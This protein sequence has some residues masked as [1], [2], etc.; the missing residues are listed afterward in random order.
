MRNLRFLLLLLIAAITLC[1]ILSGQ[2]NTTTTPA[3]TFPPASTASPETAQAPIL[4]YSPP[5]AEYARAKAY[6]AAHYRHFFINSLYGLL[7]LLVLLRWRVAPRFRDLAERVSRRRFVQL[8]IFAPL[9]LLTVSIVTI[10]SDIWDQSLQRAFGLS[11]QKW[12]AWLSDW[13]TGQIIMLIVGT[14][15]VGILYAVIRRSPRRWWFYFWLASIPILLALFFLQPLVI[16]PLF[17][18]FKPL[19]GA[20]PGLVTEIE[21]VTHRGGIEIPR[22]RMFVM[23]ASSK[24]TGLNAYVTGYGA[25]KRVV[26]WD[27]T[28]A[29]AT[30]PETLFVFGHEMGHYVLLHI[31]KE[32]AINAAL[33]LF[34]L[35]LGFRLVHWMLARFGH[36]WAIRDLDDWASFPA[37]MFLITLLAFLATPAFNAVSR[38]FEHEADRYGLEVIHGIVSDPN[39]V[40]AH[41]FEKSGE[42]NLSDPDPSQWDKAWF[43]DHPTRKERVHFVATYN[44]WTTGSEPKYV[45]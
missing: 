14:I 20:S 37:L 38:H 39:Q 35:Y 6:S 25:S 19:A 8:I 16:D 43:F 4:E 41:Y 40:A 31:P 15:L 29:K 30:I 44:P 34:L 13:I 12:P 9:I 1:A 33:L 2:T 28:I 17:Y 42:M 24:E 45:K 11:V 27:N 21:K 5:P 22:D 18:T 3:T 23:N 10:P 36:Q 26:V 32:I 7:V